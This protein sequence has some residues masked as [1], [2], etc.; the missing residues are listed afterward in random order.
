V[1]TGR[2]VPAIDSR[3]PL[4]EIVP[5]LRRVHEGQARGKVVITV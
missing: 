3:F 5:A 2:L 4:D 1:A